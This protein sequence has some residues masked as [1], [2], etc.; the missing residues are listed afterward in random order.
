MP[1]IW[2]S[3]PDTGHADLNRP[4]FEDAS[5]KLI[6][7]GKVTIPHDI[8]PGDTDHDL[9]MEIC[10]KHILDNSE[11]VVMLPGWRDSEGAT[12]EKQVAVGCGIPVLELIA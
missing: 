4:A 1:D 3:G 6:N 9:A 8:V 12:L 7:L 10:L 2:I 11:Y 5:D